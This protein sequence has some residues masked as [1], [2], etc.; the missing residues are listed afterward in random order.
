MLKEFKYV[1][2]NWEDEVKIG[3]VRIPEGYEFKRKKRTL[4][5]DLKGKPLKEE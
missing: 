3:D 2:D 4:E 5:D 1:F